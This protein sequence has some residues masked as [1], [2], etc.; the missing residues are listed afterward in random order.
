MDLDYKE[1]SGFGLI[2]NKSIMNILSNINDEHVREQYLNSLRNE[3]KDKFKEF[4]EMYKLF[5]EA[6]G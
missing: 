1:D 4:M 3:N 6:N 5:E 2:R